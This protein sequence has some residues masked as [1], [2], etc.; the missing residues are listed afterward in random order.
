[1]P[2]AARQTLPADCF[3]SAGHSV[4]VPVQVSAVSQA[5]AAARHSAPAWPAGCWQLSA[6]PSHW[7]SVQGLPSLVHVVPLGCFASAGHAAPE[8]VQCSATS[9]SPAAAR[10]TVLAAWKASA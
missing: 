10:Q 4:L 3:A 5:P 1:A 8:P 2:A 6:L 7:S 9:H